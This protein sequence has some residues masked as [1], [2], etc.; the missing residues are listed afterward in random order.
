M[1]TGRDITD[2]PAFPRWLQRLEP[3][4]AEADTCHV[5]LM[6]RERRRRMTI[7]RQLR[8][9]LFSWTSLPIALGVLLA[10]AVTLLLP[11]GLCLLILLLPVV[12]V[13]AQRLQGALGKGRGGVPLMV[14]GIATSQGVYRE[15]LVDLYLA[16]VSGSDLIRASALE[17]LP[18]ALAGIAVAAL[19]IAAS[20]ALMTNLLWP[21][22]PMEWTYFILSAWL[23]VEMFLSAARTLKHDI[24][25]GQ[26]LPCVEYWES[27]SMGRQIGA[28]LGRSVLAFLLLFGLFSLLFLIIFLTSGAGWWWLPIFAVVAAAVWLHVARRRSLRTFP[29]K[30]TEFLARADHAF[31][32]YITSVVPDDPDGRDWADRYHRRVLPSLTPPS[33]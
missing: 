23:T 22:S 11:G 3:F 25:Q 20:F 31:D 12:M 26:L 4:F 32:V 6:F 30:V 14:R 29:R 27:K 17:R 15:A 13:L 24:I 19:G 21:F 2:A 28:A 1:A 5:Y 18:W 7:G 10:I 16:G 33:P 8:K 9:G